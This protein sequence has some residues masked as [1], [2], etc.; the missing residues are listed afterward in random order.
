MVTQ[1]E[2]EALLL[3][4]I[5]AMPKPQLG[6]LA[7]SIIPGLSQETLLSVG[8]WQVTLPDRICN[9]LTL[10]IS[11][12]P[13]LPKTNH[14]TSLSNVPPLSLCHF[15]TALLPQLWCPRLYLTVCFFRYLLW[16]HLHCLTPTLGQT[17]LPVCTQT[18]TLVVALVSAETLPSRSP[19][20]FT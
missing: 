4:M 18:L 3:G 6:V 1:P 7:A 5:L 20:Q 16:P 11:S 9:S 2:F 12:A 10:H 8:V 13:H 19:L 15:G 17:G 14:R